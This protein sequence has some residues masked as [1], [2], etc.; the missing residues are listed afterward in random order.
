MKAALL[1]AYGDIDQFTYGDAKTPVAG[2]GEVL[3]K[4][5]AS[6]FNPVD[7]YVRQGYL[8]QMMPMTMPAILGIDVAGTVA[9]LGSG[10]TTWKVGDRV[11]GKVPING[12]G[13]L[14][15]YTVAKAEALATL[16]ANVSFIDGAALP[17]S[18]LTG[19]QAVAALG[20]V[21]GKRILV[22][23]GLG[24]A[25]RAAIQNLVEL[26]AVPVAGVRAS[27]LGL[28][29][30]LGVDA[31]DIE[32]TPTALRSFDGAVTMVGGATV[33]TAIALVRDGGTLAAV[34]GVPDGD[35]ADGRIKVASVYTTDN[36]KM[37]QEIADDAGRGALKIPVAKTFAVAE[38]AEGHKLA[39][40]GQLGGKIVFVP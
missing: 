17:L 5:E 28:A 30:A 15:D 27:R 12:R 26:G 32:A 22:T 4:V 23:G 9:A 1:K 16:P 7:L 18:G 35:N 13:S 20:D 19:W 10:V 6:G 36:A 8:A 31:I 11:V 21:K 25:G 24:A 38:V 37:L 39:A 3:V 33:A 29:R 2:A 40:A 14:A 34:A